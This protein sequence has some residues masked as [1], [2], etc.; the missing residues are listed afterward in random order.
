MKKYL[1]CILAVFFALAAFSCNKEKPDN[2]K[3]GDE[4]KEFVAQRFNGFMVEELAKAYESFVED[5]KLPATVYVEGYPYGKGLYIAAAC[6]LLKSIQEDPHHWEDEE[7][8]LPV[9]MSWGTSLSNNTFE[10]DTISLD[11]LSWAAE[12]VFAYGEQHKCLPNYVSF[13]KITCPGRGQD[14]TYT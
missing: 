5:D 12:K 10:Q 8:D 4:P 14:S 13:G 6:L 9:T 3:A 11:A 7:I 2:G 1:F